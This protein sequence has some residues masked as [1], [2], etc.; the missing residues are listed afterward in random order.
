MRV[1]SHPTRIRQML[2]SRLKQLESNRAS[3]AD[4]HLV[5]GR[6]NAAGNHRVPAIMAGTRHAPGPPP[7]LTPRTAARPRTVYVP[8]DLPSTRSRL[9]TAEHKRLKTILGEVS[10]LTL[11][12]LGQ[13]PRQTPP[14]PPGSTLNIGPILA[15][16]TRHFFPDF[17][18]WI[19]TAS[20]TPRN[21][22]RMH[23]R[24]KHFLVWV[25]LMLFVCKLS[26]RRQV[27]Y[28]FS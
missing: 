23:L 15:Q 20:R 25:G 21:P 5:P 12:A 3:R 19:W 11:K 28:Q 9:W 16:T 13:G 17:R 1:P 26:S 8:Q 14:T 10:Q 27:N 4:G 2:D 6:T 7:D 22:L 18:D 24:Q